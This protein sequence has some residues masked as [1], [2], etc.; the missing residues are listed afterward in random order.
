MP[1]KWYFLKDGAELGPF[2]SQE[3]IQLA[4]EDK[5]GRDTPVKLDLD[6]KWHRASE[7]EGLFPTAPA[8]AANS[9]QSGAGTT[10]KMV[11]PS[12]PIVCPHCWEHFSYESILYVARHQD[13]RGDPVIG[14]DAQK[15]FLPTKFNTKGH[16]I[17]ARGMECEDIAC[18]HCHLE[19]PYSV[20]TLE[21]LYFSIIGA[22]SSGKSFFLT[23]L[24]AKLR[25]KLPRH[26]DYSFTDAD[27]VFNVVVNDYVQ[28]LFDN[29]FPDSFV[30][31]PKTDLRGD[32]FSNQITLNGMITDLPK[33]FVFKIEPS[34]THA[35]HGKQAAGLIRN[36]VFYDNAGEHILPGQDSPNNPATRHLA[37]SHGIIFLFDPVLDAGMRRLCSSGDPQLKDDSKLVNQ[38]VLFAE[39]I[40]RIRKMTGMR[41][42]GAYNSPLIIAVSKFDIWENLL[43]DDNIRALDPWCYNPQTRRNELDYCVVA[44]VSYHLRELMLQI[45]PDIVAAAEA[46][47]PNVFFIPVSALGSNSIEKQDAAPPAPVEA[48]RKTVRPGDGSPS[49]SRAF[50]TKPANV[51][52]VWCET[53]MLLL[54]A[55]KG[56]FPLNKSSRHKGADPESH[57]FRRHF[58][59][60]RFPNL[61]EEIKL[62]STYFGT[63]VYHRELKAWINIPEN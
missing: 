38:A 6:G 58:V 52:P 21:S 44:N 19:I 25:D 18:P 37:E 32:L 7:L 5:L 53:P 49:L 9:G 17:D 11:V 57:E 12:T 30:T 62:P 26:F 15:R 36:L 29:E 33:P 34:G 22:P 59:T 35:L 42:G 27:P 56:Y 10:G 8:P 16:A 20:I 47:S 61:T 4:E 48:P 45:K 28:R 63:T 54:L 41:A 50:G 60:L 55:L 46:F 31:L 43:P 14:P 51:K 24:I 23:A 1:K 2:N 13:L 3:L 40:G 39:M